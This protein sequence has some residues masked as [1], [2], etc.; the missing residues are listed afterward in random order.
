MNHECLLE[1]NVTNVSFSY[2]FIFMITLR[3]LDPTIFYYR[4]DF[5]FF[6]LKLALNFMVSRGGVEGGRLL[7]L[8]GF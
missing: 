2:L 3:R 7:R 1:R 5:F 8:L 6:C 4:T